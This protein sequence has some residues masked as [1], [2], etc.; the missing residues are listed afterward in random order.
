M[1]NRTVDIAILTVI[2]QELAA[3]KATM[4][5]QDLF[6]NR[7]R[8]PDSQTVYLH[9]ELISERTQERYS[10]ALGCIGRAGN[11]DAASA[12]TE[13]IQTYHPKLVVLMGIAAGIKGKA[14]LGE[15]TFSERV[16]GYES[17]ALRREDGA[18][19]VQPRPDM[20]SVPNRIHQDVIFYLAACKDRATDYQQ[21]LASL[22]QRTGGVFPTLSAEDRHHLQENDVIR[23]IEIDV[24]AIASGEKLLKDPDVLKNIQAKQHGRVKV[25]E[26]EA[27]GFAMA[28]QRMRRDWLVIRGVSDF[29][30]A[31][32][33]DIF[34][35]LASQAVA[36]VLADF[37]RYGLEL[38]EGSAKS[39]EVLVQQPQEQVLDLLK[40][41][42]PSQFDTVI[43]RY[44]IEAAHLSNGTQYQQAIDLIRYAI[45]KEGAEL[46]QLLTVIYTVAPH[47][48]E[49]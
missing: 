10:I 40:Q 31:Y 11:Y 32:K 21:R 12:T 48:K 47:L 46:S 24:C 8:T 33:S 43:F 19:A 34:H 35:P 25:G 42:L 17:A 20:P 15:V 37:L 49:R 44:G 28:C 3:A 36:T 14:R 38:G 29:G 27:I 23:T 16:V 5:I 22:F 39:G 4:G 41:L 13:V 9:E 1:M 18:Q 26:M 45:Q 30:D 7:T 6:N 2:P